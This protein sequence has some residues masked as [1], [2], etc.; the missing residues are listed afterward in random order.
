MSARPYFA[1]PARSAWP[2]RG[3]VTGARFAPFASGSGCGPVNIV[4]CQFT[5]SRFSISIAIGPPMRLAG[6]HA[7]EDVG[8]IRLDRHPPATAVAPLST[9]EFT[10]NAVEV[11][12]KPGGNAFENDDEGAA[13]RFA[14]SEKSHH[15]ER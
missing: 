15:A 12:A 5:Q 4:C 10:G 6:A 13:V 1:T 2:G 7:G 8:P 9:P 14:S 11:D 3:R